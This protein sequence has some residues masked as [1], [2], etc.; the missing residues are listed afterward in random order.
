MPNIKAL[1]EPLRRAGAPEVRPALLA[2]GYP[3]HH[4]RAALRLP[5]G[6]SATIPLASRTV[7]P[8]V[9]LGATRFAQL[10]IKW[11]VTRFQGRDV[12]CNVSTSGAFFCGM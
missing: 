12:A 8:E 3:L 2:S 1:G 7:A 4:L 6:G 5:F 10:K 11:N 9:R